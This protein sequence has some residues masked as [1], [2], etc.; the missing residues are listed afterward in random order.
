M[1]GSFNPLFV[2][3]KKDV[4]ERVLATED[5]KLYSSY[6][7]ENRILHWA[8]SSFLIIKSKP[9]NSMKYMNLKGNNTFIKFHKL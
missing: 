6:F 4:S 3:L 5:L 1:I 8:I 9:Q 2:Q 7:G